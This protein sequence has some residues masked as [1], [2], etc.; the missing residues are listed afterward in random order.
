M[1]T[2]RR[3][4]LRGLAVLLAAPVMASA[5]NL[6]YGAVP[7][8]SRPQGDQ[9]AANQKLD[10][11]T[12]LFT[13][14]FGYQVRIAAPPGRGGWD[15]GVALEY[16]SANKNGWCGVG[17]DLDLGYIQRDTRHGVLLQYVFDGRTLVITYSNA[18]GFVFSAAGQS[19]RLI[20]AATNDYRPQINKGFLKFSY[21]NGW[22][23]GTDKGG[24]AYYF[25]ETAT[26]CI[27]NTYGTFKW[28]LSSIHDPNGNKAVLSYSRDGGQ[29]YLQRMDYNANDNS[30]AIATNCTV[31]FDLEST[32]R[33]DVVSSVISG[34][35]II[36]QKRLGAI[37]VL[38]QGQLV[39]RYQLQ[40]TNS[41]STGRSLLQKVTEYG[42]DNVTSLPAHTFSYQVQAQSFEPVQRW[43]F[44]PQVSGSY[45]WGSPAT[46]DTQLVDINGDGLPDW[47]SRPLN[48]PFDHFVV[49]LNTGSGF[50]SAQNWPV[51][52]EA[53]D[54]SL[55]SLNTLDYRY[56]PALGGQVTSCQLVDLN[57]DMLP[58]RVMQAYY[59]PYNY[60]GM[61]LNTGTGFSTVSWWYNVLD[62]YSAPAVTA[63]GTALNPA[64]STTAM[65]ADMNGDGLADLVTTTGSCDQ[66]N[67][68][69][70]SGNGTFGGN[71]AWGNVWG[72]AGIRNEDSYGVYSELMDLNGDGLPDRVIVGGAQLN[73]GVSGFGSV[74]S[75]GL[76][77]SEPFAV[78]DWSSQCFSKQL[79]DINGDGLPDL[80]TANGDST[81]SVR[82]NTGRGFS[83]TSVTWSGVDIGGV[84]SPGWYG[85]QAWDEG[86]AGSSTKIMFIDIDGDGLPDRVKRNYLG[87]S[88]CLQVQLNSGPFPDLLT[89]VN[90]GIGG[91]VTIAY[92]PSTKYNNSD[93]NRPR[94]PFPVYTVQSV[95][96]NDGRGN[97]GTTSYNYSGGLYD[98][99]Y[100]E[101]R[102]FA[103]VTETDPLNAYT[104]TFFHQG[105]GT[106]ASALGE[107]QD[108]LAKAGMAYR[109]ERY[110]SDGKLYGRTLNR[111]GEVQVHSTGV[112]FPFVQQT[113]KQDYEGNGGY[114]ASAVGYAY[115]AVSN[116]LATSTGNLL[117]QTNYGEVLSVNMSGH[118]FVATNTTAP[119][120]R[121][122]TYAV[123]SGNADILDRVA[124]AAISADGAG[125]VAL[126][127]TSNSYYAVT[128]DLQTKNEL[129]CPGTYAT[130]SYTYDNYGNVL[131]TTDPVG[132]V[133]T[134]GYDAGIA[135]YP[136]IKYTGTLANNLMEYSLYDARSG[137][138]LCATNLQ[139]LVTSNAYD[140]FFR[141]TNASISTVA[142]GAPSLWRKQWQYK[143]G[144]I[145]SNNSSNYVRLLE[146]DPADAVNG[147]HESYTYFDGLG[148][149]IQARN[150]AENGQYRVSDVVYD[151]R[152]SVIL[153]EYP[154]FQSA[155][156]YA[157][158]SGTRTNVYTQYD[159]IGRPWRINPCASASFNGS[160]WLSGTP[161]VLTGDSG[162]PVGPTSWDYNDGTNSWAIVVTN[163][164]GQIH[165]YYLDGFGRTNVVVEV[166]GQGNYTN[167]LGWDLVGNLT[168]LTDNAGNQMSFFYNDLGQRVALADPD[169]GFWQYGLDAAGRLKVQT[170]AKQQ[171]IKFYYNDPAGRPTRREGWN[172]ATQ[173]VSAVTYL[174]DS[175]GGDGQY[176]V[177]PG[178]LFAV[179]DDEG[180]EK[181]S[182][183]VRGRRLKTARYLS[184]NGQTY[185]TSRTFD[186]ADRMSSVTYP[187]GGPTVTNLFDTGENLVKVQRV[188]G[189]GSNIVYYAAQGF[190]EL[191]RLTGI[192]FGN[193][194]ATTFNFYRTSK[195]LNQI[196]TTSSAGTMQNFT[197]RY[198][199]VGNILGIQDLVAGHTDGASA[200]LT[201]ATYDDLNR[202]IAAGWTGYGQ[203]NYAYDSVGNVRTN[204]EFGAGNYV[205]GSI[206]PHCV[207]SA[208]GAWYAYDQNG[209]VV[210]RTG[211]RLDY[212]VNNRLWRVVSTNG[213]TT[214]FGYDANGARLWEQSGTNALQVWIGDYY[215]EKQGQALYHILAGG[216]LICTFDST[217]TNVFE[218]YHSDYLT[219]T[220]IQ[221]DQ[222]GNQIQH[223][224]YSAFGQSRYT[225]STTTFQP[226]RRYTGQVLDD[227]TGLYYYN[228]RF[229]DPQLGRFIQPDD[230]IPDLGN[231]QS[232]NR[233]SYV[234]NDPFRY[235]DPSGHE[236][237]WHDVGQVFLG[238]YDA[239]AG[240]VKGTVFVVAH[241]IR[242]VE[243][244][245]TVI[246]HPINT[247][248]AVW[249][250][251]TE[252]WESGTRGQG[253]VV[254]DVLI[255][256]GT[257]VA[258]AAQ[259]GNVS[260]VGQAA[261][262]TSK[263]EE[264]A[265]GA[266]K[267]GAVAEKTGTVTEKAAETTAKLS[268]VER[269]S[270]V[271]EI[272]GGK[273]T[274]TT[275]V[276]PG[277]GPGQ[278]RAEYVR[279]KNQ[280]GETIRTYKDP[281][282]RAN[283]F[284]HRKPLRGGPE[285]RP[286]SE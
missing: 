210:F 196:I 66:F 284:Q 130:T 168:N 253:K 216:R 164:L 158:P 98:T 126:Q 279:Y 129:I 21:T 73:D 133:T 117:G 173:L 224:E 258:P 48:A 285:G 58:D 186:D 286:Q 131:T 163:A 207:R 100:R 83:S 122:F 112:F 153:E 170:D 82:F 143:L 202:L 30:P 267:V 139:G 193:G 270:T 18:M 147:Y 188:D 185:V 259:A 125:T 11:H 120:Y 63:P 124:L 46:P 84:G 234:L 183:D 225:Q 222:S 218:F 271:E 87:G 17:W 166:T 177:Y 239:G 174:Y 28:A 91:S 275:D 47:V 214:M 274:K 64:S 190:D 121:Q 184:K 38:S 180:W 57:G 217:G 159:A 171:Q 76:G 95:T 34:S 242:T 96:V 240:V 13:G 114:R 206:R 119:V 252:S 144:G 59:S 53:Y 227:A 283:N 280:Q 175:S 67:V 191:D 219:S 255:A 27:T 138:L 282:D 211:Q 8:L 77:G 233:Y 56:V 204:G 137:A 54:N 162:S 266:E 182:Y 45:Y 237:Y 127:Q 157:K 93:G 3:W 260:R 154:L 262:L 52:N 116:S 29:L 220:S 269:T 43:N 195:R 197:N 250:A 33:S 244:L 32:N 103:V 146:N 86:G 4:L 74:L 128:G 7:A 1:K 194:A 231:P 151:A 132:V 141:L 160:G 26:S 212:D 155:A 81:F 149:P 22:W 94:L 261:S 265:Q 9:S 44:T 92:L 264:L 19:G 97:A 226:S 281:Y 50:G 161:T 213:V 40:Y 90:N 65:L 142:N 23:V 273:F 167:R 80:V 201:N 69:L 35:E 6:D 115:S 111:V 223:Y 232:Y 205:Y 14:R 2:N 178:Q 75:W 145:V 68:Q 172:A 229:Y 79:I 263:A 110:G 12:D 221:T 238:Y 39:R 60:F 123:I 134:I 42:S 105:G 41:P 209:N 192:N 156:G 89:N 176:T 245:G 208:N 99:T 150:E 20:Q 136:V 16:N 256:V 230:I 241:P 198:D 25:G 140:V 247:G 187:N 31:A 55:I 49:Q 37:R 278:S 135:T 5:Q 71:R 10:Y 78:V 277:K 72:C 268:K 108:D 179:Y 228:F 70:N 246:A 36:T 152:G 109:V 249:N 276:R 51:A 61:Q 101:F 107:F 215:E 15:P 199:A 257:A 85:M 88:D 181:N 248:Q 104:T 24:R 200:T 272:G 106:N 118:S 165:K 243:G 169:M 203:K 62:S 102:G 189:G 235:T 254:G 148:R 113:I 251:A 236:G